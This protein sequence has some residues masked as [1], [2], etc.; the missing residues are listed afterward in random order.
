[1]DLG[2]PI[3]WLLHRTSAIRLELVE[4]LPNQLD[5]VFPRRQGESDAQFLSPPLLCDERCDLVLRAG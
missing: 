5:G 1:M 3:K 2:L 4:D